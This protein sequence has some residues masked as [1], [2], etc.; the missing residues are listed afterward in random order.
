MPG[1]GRSR[2][3]FQVE[4]EET[5]VQ[6]PKRVQ[7]LASVAVDVGSPGDVAKALALA[8]AQGWD[9]VRAELRPGAL[10][11]H[12][13]LPEGG[14]A[15]VERGRRVVQGR[16]RSN[17]A[18]RLPTYPDDHLPYMPVTPPGSSCANCRHVSEDGKSCAQED[19]RAWN[20]GPDLRYPA[21]QACSDWWEPR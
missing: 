12:V 16:L 5:P 11:L 10:T 9:V 19:F 14:A 13:N 20:G 7:A 21:D 1:S 4:D 17:P 18:R 8:E 2:T 6:V 15:Q 3:P